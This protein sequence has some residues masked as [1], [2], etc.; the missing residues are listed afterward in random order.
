[1]LSCCEARAAGSGTGLTG[2]V[3][4]RPCHGLRRSQARGTRG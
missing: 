2:Q 4:V 3:A 1:M